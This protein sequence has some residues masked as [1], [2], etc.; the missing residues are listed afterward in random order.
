VVAE[1]SEQ[2]RRFI[3]DH[4]VGRLA[5]ADASGRPHVVPVCYAYDGRRIYTAL[6]RKPKRVSARGLKRV[7]N[8]LANPNVA[9]I[10]DHYSEDW[11]RLAYVLV[12]GSAVLLEDG[13]ERAAAERLLRDKYPQYHG[14]LEEGSIVIR[15]TPEKVV[16]WGR[17]QD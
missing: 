15:I 4:R 3:A 9:L 16:S 2:E 12:Q 8:V 10:I 17:V 7:R 11:S 1:V 6:D 14:L 13:E 5:T